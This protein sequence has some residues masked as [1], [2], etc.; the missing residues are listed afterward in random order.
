MFLELSFC[1]FINDVIYLDYA[2]IHYQNYIKKEMTKVIS[3]HILFR[4]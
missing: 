4:L 2:W 3:L 1:M